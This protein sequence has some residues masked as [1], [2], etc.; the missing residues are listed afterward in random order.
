[1]F[2][3]SFGQTAV[4]VLLV[5]NFYQI[6]GGEDA[7]V[8]HEQSILRK[9]GIDVELFSVTNDSITGPVSRMAT[10]FRVIY[11]PAARRAMSQTL[12]TFLPDI[13][14]VHNFFPLLS[15]SIFDACRSAGVPTVMSLHN[16]RI[17]SPA[18]LLHPCELG[19]TRNL[20]A[21]CWW[22]VLNRVYRGSAAATLAVAAMIEFH[23]HVGTWHRK[24]DCFIA[25]TNWARQVFIEGGLPPG[26][27]VV[28]PN[29]VE[30]PRL[31]RERTRHGALFVGRLDEQKGVSTLLRAWEQIE[32][33]LTI[34]GD[35]P[36]SAAVS[37]RRRYVTYLGRQSPDVVQ[38]EMQAA[39]FLILPSQGFE[40]LPLTLLEAFAN[41]LPVICSD[42]PSLGDLV[43][44]GVTGLCFPAGDAAGLAHQV[45]Y[46]IANPL[47]LSELGQ[48]AH[49][50]YEQRFT[51]EANLAGLLA[52]YRSLR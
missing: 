15:P 39:Q 37:Q 30:R 9:A 50:S 48:R 32:Y 44:P 41:H 26:R 40:M 8:R 27:I 14:H 52:I 21:P 12:A 23:K 47:A 36:L 43:E 19:P 16:Y 45:R 28:K 46:A 29:C 4:R 42:L 22:T 13:V 17:L 38:R 20:K 7:C 51:P 11:N 33:P 6:P 3:T 1:V 2:G 5:H 35:G 18:A 24:V 49:A 34:I 31:L 25:L 10:A